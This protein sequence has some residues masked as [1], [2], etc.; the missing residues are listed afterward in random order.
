[1]MYSCIYS[2]IFGRVA[3]IQTEGVPQ[4][5]FYMCSNTLWGMFSSTI[6]RNANVFRDNQGLF[7]KVYF[8]RLTVPAVPELWITV[9]LILAGEPLLL[10]FSL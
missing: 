8:S 3:G 4:F 2:I 6:H 1:M 7:G 5:L 9:R 10:T